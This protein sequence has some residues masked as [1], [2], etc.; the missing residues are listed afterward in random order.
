MGKGTSPVVWSRDRLPDAYIVRSHHVGAGANM[1]FR[2]AALYDASGFDPAL[3]VGTPSHG[4]GDL[5]MFHRLL[6][7]GWMIHYEPAAL[8]WH[9]HRAELNELERQLCDNGRAYGVHLLRR[10]RDGDISRLTT[11]RVAV[12]WLLWLTGRLVR[13]V[14]KREKMPLRFLVG[15]LRGALSAPWAY[16]LTYRDAGMAPRPGLSRNPG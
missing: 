1:I 12:G 9:R 3:D 16:Y 5:D 7:R 6:V 8:V 15:E 10:L 13:R 4:A 14:L 2:R 11:L